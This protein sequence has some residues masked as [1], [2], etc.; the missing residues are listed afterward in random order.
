MKQRG[1]TLIELL[2]VVA[3]LG[4]IAAVFTPT[5]WHLLNTPDNGAANETAVTNETLSWQLASGPITSLNLTQLDFMLDYAIF[6]RFY[7]LA[8]LYQN[9]IIINKFKEQP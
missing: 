8:N 6:K 4:I 1:F 5:V 7:D 3:I 2:I 9:Q